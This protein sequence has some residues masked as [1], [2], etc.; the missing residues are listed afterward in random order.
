MVVDNLKKII[1]SIIYME[2]MPVFRK[3]NILKQIQC[4]I[5]KNRNSMR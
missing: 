5:K 1:H 2:I 4:E 3:D